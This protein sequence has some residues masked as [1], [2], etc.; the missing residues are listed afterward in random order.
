VTGLSSAIT[1]Q[2][3]GYAVSILAKD[4]PLPSEAILAVHNLINYTSPWGGAHNRWIPPPLGSV[5][6]HA[7]AVT[8]YHRMHALSRSN[9]EAGV[10][11]MK[12][13]EYIEAPGPEYDSL[14]EQRARTELGMPGWRMLE[15]AEFPDE[16]VKWGCEYDTWCVNPMVYCAFL[17]RRF[18]LRGGRVV[19]GVVREVDEVWAMRLDLGRADGVVNATGHGFGDKDMFVTRGKVKSE[20]L[21]LWLRSRG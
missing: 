19:Q 9:P 15:E 7:W 1:L 20:S 12:G 10:T 14:T 4:L 6:E 21:A 13:I 18:V 17:L 2:E 11:F 8:T 5:R 16:R 3:K